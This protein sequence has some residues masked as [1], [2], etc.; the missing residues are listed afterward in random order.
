MTNEQE[1]QENTLHKQPE[2]RTGWA[3]WIVIG[4]V[5][6]AAVAGIGVATALSDDFGPFQSHFERAGWG[7]EGHFGMHGGR[8][9]A[10]RHGTR[11]GRA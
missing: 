9:G 10:S 5:G 7:G 2:A 4:G 6:L 1:N 11:A 8:H 3:K